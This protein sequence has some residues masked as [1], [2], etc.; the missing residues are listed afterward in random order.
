MRGHGTQS[1]F[2]ALQQVLNSHAVPFRTER[3]PAVS[4]ADVVSELNL[5]AVLELL[6]TQG[7]PVPSSS[8]PWVVEELFLFSI[9][10]LDT[11]QDGYRWTGPQRRRLPTWPSNWV[12][13]A[14]IVG[15]PFIADVDGPAVPIYFAPHGAGAW[16]ADRVAPT[17]TTFLEALTRFESVLLGDFDRDVWDEDGL[18]PDFLR[19][20]KGA[21]TELLPPAGMASF[22]R[23][24]T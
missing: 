10:E 17:V 2:D 3:I 6:Y 7:G 5:P 24:L 4:V 16:R 11:A 12:V 9:R 14:A 21:L 13:I 15:D 8:V 23:T 18:R 1:G 22:V 20:V 19:T